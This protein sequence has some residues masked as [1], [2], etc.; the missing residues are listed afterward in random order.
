MDKEMMQCVFD[1]A[2][3]LA[4]DKIRIRLP[5]GVKPFAVSAAVYCLERPVEFTGRVEQDML[6]ISGLP[7]GRYGIVVETDSAGWEG[8]FD[9]VTCRREIIRYGFLADFSSDDA[10][11]DDID[12]MKD[13]HLNAVQFYDWMYRHDQLLPPGQEYQDPMGRRTN[14]GVIS[15]KIARCRKNGMR[16]VAYGAVYAATQSTYEEHPEWGMYTMDGQPMTFAGW[17]YYMNI[18]EKSG[19]TAHLLAEYEKTLRFGFQGIHMDTYG[20]PK[21]VW[22][23]DGQPIDLKEEFA[24]LI[25]RAADIA[26]AEDE[27]GG[28]IFNAVNNWPVE[29]VAGTGQDAVYIE[30][31]PPNDAYY[32]LYTLVREARLCSGKNVV[33]AAYMK[34]FQLEDAEAAE[35]AL[36]L[37]WAAICAS[38][39]T[40]LVFGEKEG[41]LQDSY[42]VNYA[43][44]RKE[45]LPVVQRYCDFLV[46]YGDLLYNDS[47]TDVSKTASGGINEDICFDADD[48]VFSVDGRPNTV[49]TIIRESEGRVTIQLVNLRGNNCLWNEGKNEPQPVFHVRVSFRLDRQVRGFYCASPDGDSLQAVKLACTCENTGQGRIYT[50]EIP[51]VRYW[52]AVWAQLEG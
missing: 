45:F 6:V 41:V 20:F 26:G 14:L 8:A 17:L 13:L 24:G 5:G 52:T 27:N 16:P 38:G 34:P 40:Q 32:D 18:S 12:W 33:L 44:L 28:V 11:T 15:E 31:W 7:V 25:N 9:I 47:G 29:A 35:R 36:R 10:G 49:W 21:R 22:D 1:R 2:Q 46:R 3:Y 4:G 37:T 48:C 50:V 19:W 23:S 42:Y 51:G 43:K 30:V 39:G